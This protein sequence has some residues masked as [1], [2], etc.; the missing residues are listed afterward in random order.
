MTK[1]SI[2]DIISMADFKNKFEQD[3]G[4]R[5][6]FRKH[7]YLSNFHGGYPSY[8]YKIAEKVVAFVIKKSCVARNRIMDIE[9]LRSTPLDIYITQFL[10]EERL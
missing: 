3:S 4:I 2:T 1:T 8:E 5:L 9:S 10:I 7:V 6:D